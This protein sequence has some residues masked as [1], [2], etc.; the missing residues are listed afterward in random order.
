MSGELFRPATDPTEYH[1]YILQSHGLNKPNT[2]YPASVLNAAIATGNLS[3]E[4]AK[5]AHRLIITASK[6]QQYFTQGYWN[7]NFLPILRAVL[8]T[9]GNSFYINSF[10]IKKMSAPEDFIRNHLTARDALVGGNINHAV[11]TPRFHH[12]DTLL[13]IIDPNSPNQ[14]RVID[15][16]EFINLTSTHGYITLVGR[17]HSY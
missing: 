8:E 17:N 7:T 3:Y 9:G 6:Y 5:S 12:A 16:R 15:L 11:M 1:Q 4:A 10:P 14:P 13:E 2:C